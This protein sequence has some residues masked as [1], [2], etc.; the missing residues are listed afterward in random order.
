MSI[1]SYIFMGYLAGVV[2]TAVRLGWHMA[3]HL[4]GFDWRYS[5]ANNWTVFILSMLLWPL[6]LI[7]PGNLIDPSKL[8]E[9]NYGIAARK[10]EQSRMSVNPPPCGAQVLYQ[11]YQGLDEETFGEFTFK[12]T[13]VENALAVTLG[14]NPQLEK[15]DEGSILNWLRRRDDAITKATPVP[16]T[17]GRFEFIA[18]D[19][20]RK[21]RGEV[22]CLKCETPILISKLLRQDDIGKPGWNFNRLLCPNNHQLL[23]V[24]KMHILV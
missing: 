17:W 12:S 8:F 10:R 24:E 15:A 4:D 5:K 21:G 14:E 22:R 11:Q 6:T 13:D 19:L 23:V 2:L 7:R 20:V 16:S 9:G 1:L 18:D 3:V